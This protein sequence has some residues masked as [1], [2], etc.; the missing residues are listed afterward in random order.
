[1]CALFADIE[2]F[3]I[4]L[5]SLHFVYLFCKMSRQRNFEQIDGHGKLRNG[6]GKVV[7][8]SWEFVVCIVCG[9]LKLQ[10]YILLTERVTTCRFGRV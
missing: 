10:I 2:R 1:M 4:G 6:H 8:N 5:E 9:N 3:N 7:E